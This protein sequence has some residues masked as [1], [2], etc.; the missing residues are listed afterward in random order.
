MRAFP[1]SAHMSAPTSPTIPALYGLVPDVRRTPPCAV[2]ADRHTR[3]RLRAP[4]LPGLP[5][6]RPSSRYCRAER[7]EVPGRRSSSIG[8]RPLSTGPVIPCSTSRHLLAPLGSFGQL[9]HLMTSDCLSWRRR[10][11]GGRCGAGLADGMIS[12]RYPGVLA[13][14]NS[15]PASA[16]TMSCCSGPSTAVVAHCSPVARSDHHAVSLAWVD[17]QSLPP[18]SHAEHLLA[19]DWGGRGCNAAPCASR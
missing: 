17:G 15:F 16:S 8:S 2:T 10:W 9:G 11:P 4:H 7:C 1:S 12:A 13:L 19:Q 6:S 5:S 18:P 3:L 14:E